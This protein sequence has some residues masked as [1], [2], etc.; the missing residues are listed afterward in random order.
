MIKFQ[1]HDF[2]SSH[3]STCGETHGETNRRDTENF[4]AQ[5]SKIYCPKKKRRNLL[6]Y[7]AHTTNEHGQGHANSQIK[8]IQNVFPLL[9]NVTVRLITGQCVNG[10]MTVPRKPPLDSRD[11]PLRFVIILSATHMQSIRKTP[12]SSSTYARDRTIVK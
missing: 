2:S 4:R 7:T 3:V 1:E 10:T 11:D 6:R 5:W 8:Y 12:A 9:S